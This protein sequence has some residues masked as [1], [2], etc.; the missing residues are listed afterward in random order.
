MQGK[1]IVIDGTDASGKNTQTH[2]LYNRLK[3]DG[4]KTKMFSFPVYES[5][6]G[7]MVASYL[8]GEYGNLDPKI[9]ALL[10]ASDRFAQKENIISLLNEGYI[11]ILDRYIHSNIAYQ[12]TRMDDPESDNW[13]KELEYKIFKMPQADR[14]FYLNVP[15]SY[16]QNLI[17]KR[18]QKDFLKGDTKD[19]HEK[20]DNYIKE[21]EKRY[22]ELSSDSRWTVIQCVKDGVLMSKEE[23]SDLIYNKVKS[24]L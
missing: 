24:D 21:V 2:L 23:V 10:F 1:I 16:R 12:S 17:E 13:V 4:I 15:F 6:F 20:N 14:I 5:F 3:D 7:K 19:I 18:D 8:R 22:I 9:T 11:I